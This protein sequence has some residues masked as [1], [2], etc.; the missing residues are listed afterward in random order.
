MSLES[1]YEAHQA[2][3][4]A[5][6]ARDHQA[7]LDRNPDDADV[8]HLFGVV[9]HRCGYSARAAELMA[10]AIAVRLD[11]AASHANLAEIQRALAST[12]KPPRAAAPPST[13]GRTTPRFSTTKAPRPQPMPNA[14]CLCA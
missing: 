9:H 4:Y 12:K 2:S 1:A 11:V 13:S 3:R 5:G 14:Q 8:L 7:L 10:R 6:T